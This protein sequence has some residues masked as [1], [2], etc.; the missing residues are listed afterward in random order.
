MIF[1][2]SKGES[3]FGCDQQLAS[4]R[5]PSCH[6]FYAGGTPWKKWEKHG[7][8][9]IHFSRVFFMQIFNRFQGGS[10][11]WGQGGQFSQDFVL[12]SIV[13]CVLNLKD[14]DPEM[15]T[16]EFRFLSLGKNS[17]GKRKAS[18]MTKF[19]HL[20]KY[21]NPNPGNELII[22]GGF[23]LHYAWKLFVCGS[24]NF[25][26]QVAVDLRC[27]PSQILEPFPYWKFTVDCQ[28]MYDWKYE[29]LLNYWMTLNMF[30]DEG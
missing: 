19:Y 7:T 26:N 17:G 10:G 27:S 25:G 2:C 3:H 23:S 11:F 20:E 28:T 18:P 22:I 12:C 16:V 29:W 30:L 14:E 13:I 9:F 4:H 8:I 5:N 1:Q 6:G 15:K 24:I 21:W